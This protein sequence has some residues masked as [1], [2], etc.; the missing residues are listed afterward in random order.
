MFYIMGVG[1]Y[2]MKDD[3]IGIRIVEHIDENGLAEGFEVIDLSAN[4][5]NLFSYLNEQTK[6]ILIIECALMGKKPGEFLFF[7]ENDVKTTKKM[8]GFSTHE[9]DVLKTVHLARQTGYPIPEIEFMGIEPFSVVS[10][11]GLSEELNNNME[12]YVKEAIHRISIGIR[13]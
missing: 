11:F 5:L 1:N 7:N 6:K 4:T 9:S 13:R 10:E 8:E 3:S 2:S 12:I